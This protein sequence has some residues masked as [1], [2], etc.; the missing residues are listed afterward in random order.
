ME[1]TINHDLYDIEETCS[2]EHLLTAVLQSGV[3]G[4]AVA[5]NQNIVPKSSWSQHL[6]HPGDQIILIKA[7]QGG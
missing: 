5:V 3:R 4:I 2:V 1:I 7:T 6:L